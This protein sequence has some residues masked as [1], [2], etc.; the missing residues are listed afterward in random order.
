MIN[1]KK[2]VL[3]SLIA[4]VFSVSIL[5]LENNNSEEDIEE[6]EIT[7]QYENINCSIEE[8]NFFLN[9]SCVK[10]KKMYDYSY[11]PNKYL[12]EI[13]HFGDKG[14]CW[15]YKICDVAKYEK[16]SNSSTLIHIYPLDNYFY[17]CISK[18]ELITELMDEAYFEKCVFGDE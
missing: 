5:F 12:K 7:I 17:E 8:H 3:F 15:A 13:N 14:V 16:N 10:L 9:F 18:Q 2:L 4:I 6:T 1:K 11:I